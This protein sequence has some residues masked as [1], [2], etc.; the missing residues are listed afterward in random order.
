M[1]LKI[2]ILIHL[3]LL[4]LRLGIDFH[5]HMN[6]ETGTKDCGGGW[7]GGVLMQI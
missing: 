5:L 4:I 2:I 7:P 1:V 3:F 6:P